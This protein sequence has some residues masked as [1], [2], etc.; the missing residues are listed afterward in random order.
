MAKM[1]RSFKSKGELDM[2]RG[3][4]YEVKKVG[5]EEVIVE[6]D[7]FSFLKEFDG[8]TISVSISEEKEVERAEQDIVEDDYEDEE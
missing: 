5:K 2:S 4:I 3:V 8:R 6:V 1:N 7:F